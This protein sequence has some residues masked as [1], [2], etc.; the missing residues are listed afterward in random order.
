[1]VGGGWEYMIHRDTWPACCGVNYAN[2]SRS[3]SHMILWQMW[4]VYCARQ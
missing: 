1:M 2:F 3:L 4:G